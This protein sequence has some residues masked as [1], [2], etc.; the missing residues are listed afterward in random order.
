MVKAAAE[1]MPHWNQD[2]WVDVPSSPR[3]LLAFMVSGSL[4]FRVASA[5][6][7]WASIQEK[8]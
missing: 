2:I 3:A 8:A 1:N 7:Q 4:G 5:H 6:F